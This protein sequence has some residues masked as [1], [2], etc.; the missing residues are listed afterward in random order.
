MTAS[1]IPS[2]GLRLAAATLAVSLALLCSCATHVH[3]YEQHKHYE[4]NDETISEQN[5][6][7]L[8]DRGS[9]DNRLG[10]GLD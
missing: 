1:S 2:T 9:T 5:D 8:P 10:F 6:G 7:G 4:N 3:I